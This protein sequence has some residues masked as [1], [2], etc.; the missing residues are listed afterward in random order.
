MSSLLQNDNIIH[1][2]LAIESRPTHLYGEVENSVPPGAGPACGRHVYGQVGGEGVPPVR[3]HSLEL[4][5]GAR[6]VP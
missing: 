3:H 5:Q 4:V 1:Y 6:I 2:K